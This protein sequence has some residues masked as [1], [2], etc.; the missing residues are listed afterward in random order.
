MRYSIIYLFLILLISSSCK[1]EALSFKF[2]GNIKSL[3]SGGNIGG[4]SVKA[5]T[6][7]VGNNFKSLKESTETDA[8]GNYTINVERGKY[9][10]VVI[11]LN[12]HNYFSISKTFQFGDLSTNEV[13]S[14]N[15]SLSPKSWT[16]FVLRNIYSNNPTDVLKIQ[17]ISG[18]TDCEECCPNNTTFYNGVVDTVVFCP[19]D[20][21]TN[22]KFYYWVNGNMPTG[23]INTVYNSPFDTITYEILY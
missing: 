13:N 6:Y 2:E 20:G 22:M 23:D 14:Y 11:E 12:K 5:Y 18:K 17:K 9:S 15:T 1:K 7:D 19:N 16:K 10:K 3:N 8:E 4:V 21:G